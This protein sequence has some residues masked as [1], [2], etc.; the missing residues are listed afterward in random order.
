[1]V[2]KNLAAVVVISISHPLPVNGNSQNSQE[3]SSFPS[4]SKHSPPYFYGNQSKRSTQ[5]EPAVSIKVWFYQCLTRRRN[6]CTRVFDRH[7]TGNATIV[8]RTNASCCHY[9]G[10]NIF[11][12]SPTILTWSKWSNFSTKIYF[13]SGSGIWKFTYASKL[14]ISS[15][16]GAYSAILFLGYNL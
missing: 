7:L 12:T 13:A 15:I 6:P 10:R 2:E 9:I 5:W 4:L 11:N 16:I 8:F 14:G 1:M 3:N